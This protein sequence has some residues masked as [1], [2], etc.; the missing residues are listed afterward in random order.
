MSECHVFFF[1]SKKMTKAWKKYTLLN[2]FFQRHHLIK[3]VKLKPYM[4]IDFDAVC[5]TWEPNR[6]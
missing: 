1:K 5:D 4:Y 3:G 2:Y 6:R